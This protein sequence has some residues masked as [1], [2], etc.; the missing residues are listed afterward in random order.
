MIADIMSNIMDSA[1][2]ENPT[3]TE[4]RVREKRQASHLSQKQLA[5]LAGITRQAI[6]AVEANQYS[7]STSVAL[8]LAQALRCRVE[9]LFYLK[10]DG[11][12]IEGELIGPLPKGLHKVRAQVSQ[13]GARI[14][15]RPLVGLGEL[16]SLSTT[17]DGLILGP[18]SDSKC[19][20]RT[21]SATHSDANRPPIPEETGHRSGTLRNIPA[22]PCLG[23][24]SKRLAT[25][26][27][28]A[29][30]IRSFSNKEGFDGQHEVT[31]AQDQRSSPS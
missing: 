10:S 2:E 21:K 18:G 27:N 20:F 5:D 23:V 26:G 30:T 29:V 4:N 12:V 17:A 25:L 19:V 28:T 9:D 8:K 1:K 3:E 11:E 13:I 24:K 6:C 14:L 31:H 22:T 7:P 16:P 15:V